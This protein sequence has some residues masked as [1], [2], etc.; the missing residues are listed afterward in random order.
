MSSA[1]TGVA[2]PGP[3]T[4]WSADR[5]ILTA[6]NPVT[7][8]WNNGAGLTFKRVFAVD[9]DYLFTITQEVENT[10]D[11]TVDL[12]AYQLVS[13]HGTPKVSGF[14]ILHEGPLGRLRRNPE[15]SRLR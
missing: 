11:E 9:K 12:N 2:V 3:D 7:L 8:T 4:V 15:G 6:E 14:Y 1:N 13:R 10:G 5:E